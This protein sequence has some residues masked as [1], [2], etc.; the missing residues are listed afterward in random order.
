M[1]RSLEKRRESPSRESS[2]LLLAP[3]CLRFSRASLLMGNERGIWAIGL[4]AA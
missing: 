3:N 4:N 1:N 2:P